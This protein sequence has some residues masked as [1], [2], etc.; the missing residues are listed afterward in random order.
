LEILKS[1][2][3]SKMWANVA[4]N[5][6]FMRKKSIPEAHDDGQVSHDRRPLEIACYS[7]VVTQVH[8]EE[9]ISHLAELVDAAWSGE[10]VVIIMGN[11]AVRLVPVAPQVKADLGPRF[12]AA[13]GKIRMAPDFEAPLADLASYES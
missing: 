11:E 8:L 6:D 12:G 13:A 4:T 2:S 3:T 7:F 1:G 5:A 9:A 10:P